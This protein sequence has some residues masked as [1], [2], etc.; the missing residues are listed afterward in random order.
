M[1]R[2]H[3]TDW[4]AD[5]VSTTPRLVRLW[6][7]FSAG[8]RNCTGCSEALNSTAA[9][10]TAA[11]TIAGA[12]LGLKEEDPAEKTEGSGATLCPS[13][14]DRSKSCS[15]TLAFLGRF[16]A[17]QV[18][19]SPSHEG[20]RADDRGRSLADGWSQTRHCPWAAD[21]RVGCRAS[22]RRTRTIRCGSKTS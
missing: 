17:G 8:T 7:R 11:T 21:N 12:T 10:G 20:S 16:P 19:P 18:S 6:R 1:S 9:P 14:T 3:T 5:D 2:A 22:A 13:S 15:S 4:C